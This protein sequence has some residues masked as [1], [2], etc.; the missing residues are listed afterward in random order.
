M[1]LKF[2]NIASGKFCNQINIPAYI[3]RGILLKPLYR[4]RCVGEL[5]K[6]RLKVQTTILYDT[7]LV[8]YNSGKDLWL[9]ST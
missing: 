3:V 4:H 6:P 9:S 2:E 1:H 5:L 8:L 7:F